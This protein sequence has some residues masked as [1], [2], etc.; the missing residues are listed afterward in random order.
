MKHTTTHYNAVQ[1]ALDTIES[2]EVLVHAPAKCY[3]S[4]WYTFVI[5]QFLDQKSFSDLSESE[6]QILKIPDTLKSER[7]LISMKIR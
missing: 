1:Y 2:I 3:N 4:I 5:N 6:I 7:E